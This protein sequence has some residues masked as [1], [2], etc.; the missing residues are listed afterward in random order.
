MSNNKTTRRGRDGE[1]LDPD[2][3]TLIRFAETLKLRGLATA[4]QSEY[5]RFA[6]KLLERLKCAPET[7]TEEQLRAHLL[8]LKEEHGYSP[9]SMR[10]A[11]AAMR[12]LF[13]LHIGRDW[14]LFDLVRAPSQQKLP[15]VLTRE[16]VARLFAVVR[17][18]RFRVFLRFVYATGL[19]LFEALQLQVDDLRHGDR[20]RVRGG[21]GNKD[22]YVPLPPAMLQELRRFWKTHRNPRWIFPSVGRGW[23]EKPESR[24]RLA[25]VDEPMGQGSVQHCMKIARAA[26]KLPKGTCTHTLRHSYATH[27]LEE[28]VSIRLISAYLGHSSL[29]TTLIYTHLTAVNE[30]AARAAITRLLPPDDLEP[31][32]AAVPVRV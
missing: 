20:V 19:R 14:K 24:A 21:K 27:M 2:S 1:P 22:R 13:G 31:P 12:A 18:V 7:V 17:E 23:R 8:R 29:E 26:A 6:R 15:T 9:S 16:E 25:I 28:G 10:T 30:A 4:T 3:E 32:A 5:L 11:V